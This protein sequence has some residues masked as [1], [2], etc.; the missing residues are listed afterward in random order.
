MNNVNLNL[1]SEVE[2]KEELLSTSQQLNFPSAT[3]IVKP[4]QYI[5]VVPYV[6]SGVIKVLR[7]NE[8]GDELFLYYIRKGESC[9]ESIA[10]SILNTTTNIKAIVEE[11][12]EL[13]AIPTE[14][15][16]QWFVKFPSWQLFVVKMLNQRYEELSHTLDNIAFKK[17]ES[18]LID[19]LKVKSEVLNSRVIIITHQ[20][21]SSELATSR[22]VVSRLLKALEI[23]GKVKLYRN[24]IEIIS[25]V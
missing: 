5:K 20:E 23:E 3:E 25:F 16:N 11:D 18:R 4:G 19:Y 6:L 21:I 13:L 1:F 10:K 8:N 22:E 12:V 15:V 14:K 17:V 9:A 2:L 7:I 24:K